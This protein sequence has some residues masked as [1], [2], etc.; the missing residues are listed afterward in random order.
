MQ[1]V[2]EH[3]EQRAP[4]GPAQAPPRRT[5]GPAQAGA[6][7]L[8]PCLPVE[9]SRRPVS[10]AANLQLHPDRFPQP[11]PSPAATASTWTTAAASTGSRP[12]FLHSR[13]TLRAP[14]SGHIPLLLRSPPRLSTP[15]P[16]SRIVGGALPAEPI[17]SLLMGLPPNLHKPPGSLHPRAF[18]LAGPAAWKASPGG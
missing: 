4:K 1:M 5:A 6:S 16:G 14:E 10:S 11:L 7:S 9:A 17:S 15:F 3:P 18:A 8:L 12:W 2:V 13:G